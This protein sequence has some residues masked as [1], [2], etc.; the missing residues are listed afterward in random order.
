MAVGQLHAASSR[1]SRWSAIRRIASASA[2]FVMALCGPERAAGS[3]VAELEKVD[4]R[5][6]LCKRS[7]GFCGAMARDVAVD[8]IEH[9]A[10]EGLGRLKL[11]CSEGR[12]RR[13]LRRS[14][15]SCGR[16][17]AAIDRVWLATELERCRPPDT[18]A[19]PWQKA[20]TLMPFLLITWPHG[21]PIALVEVVS[22]AMP[23][24][25]LLLLL[26]GRFLPN[27]R[28]V[29]F[30]RCQHG[31][32]PNGPPSCGHRSP[33]LP[34]PRRSPSHSSTFFTCSGEFAPFLQPCF[35]HLWRHSLTPLTHY[36]L[37]L[38]MV[39]VGLSGDV[40]SWTE[41]SIAFRSAVISIWLLVVAGSP[42]WRAQNS[43]ARQDRLQRP[44]L[45]AR[46]WNRS[47][48]AEDVQAI[49]EHVCGEGRTLLGRLCGL[50]F[51][52][53]RRGCCQADRLASDASPRGLLDQQQR[54]GPCLLLASGT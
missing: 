40:H 53:H 8:R 36:W 21:L 14:R 42:P 9:V 54:R 24:A 17:A 5:K 19:S 16:V 37:S 3:A 4:A 31:P 47:A 35:F 43:L 46:V 15:R 13:A 18:D 12:S 2:R 27:R 33:L 29:R 20:W 26:A 28:R 23:R 11:G 30:L 1:C 25:A 10:I 39:T 34:A 41:S 38:Q 22:G 48:V 44:I 50:A 7:C 49:D 6:R 52:L 45:P 32:S 51:G